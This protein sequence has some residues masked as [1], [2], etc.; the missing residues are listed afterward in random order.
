[1]EAIQLSTQGAERQRKDVMKLAAR[2]EQMMRDRRHDESTKDLND[3]ELLSMLIQRYNSYK[4][5]SALRKWQL[6]AD[7]QAA[8]FG[9]IRGMCPEARALVRAHLD[10]NKYTESAYNESILRSKRHQ[11]HE[12]PKR[13]PPAWIDKLTVTKEAQIL[14]F[15]RY[16]IWWAANSK[17]MKP[18]MRTRLRWSEEVWGRS[19]EMACLTVWAVNEAAKNPRDLWDYVQDLEAVLLSKPNKFGVEALAMWQDYCGR[20]L[21]KGASSLGGVT[22]SSEV[23]DAEELP[24]Q[25]LIV[26]HMRD[27]IQQGLDVVGRFMEKRAYMVVGERSQGVAA[28]QRRMLADASTKFNAPL[29]IS[30]MHHVGY[31]DFSKFGRLTTIDINQAAEWAKSILTLNDEYSMILAVAPLLASEGVLGGIRGEMRRIE[32]KFIDNMMECKSINIPF[33]LSSDKEETSQW[34]SG[35]ATLKEMMTA[36]VSRVSSLKHQTCLFH[37]FSCYE[38]NF[39]KVMLD[40]MVELNDR[41]Y[42]GFHSSA[43]NQTVFEFAAASVKDKLLEAQ[44]FL[45]KDVNKNKGVEFR[46]DSGE[47]MATVPAFQQAFT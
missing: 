1:M 12:A 30:K 23:E 3:E 37:H 32:D 7:A 31:I 19:V 6:N 44:D 9:V 11:L 18:S 20:A 17:R 2:F 8:I 47:S 10:F 16:N 29:D 46:L 34:V 42:I 43:P 35:L 4:A 21:A 26:L 45:S 36:C 28:L 38:G 40:L 14:H 39:E 5:N 15:R 27:Q 24:S 22:E 41:V 33:D 25:I 13:C